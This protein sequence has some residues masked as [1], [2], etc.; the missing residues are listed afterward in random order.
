MEAMPPGLPTGLIHGD[1]FCDNVLFEGE[2]FKAIL[3][4]EDACH[5]YK[6]FDVGM[7]IVGV[8]RKAAS[9]DPGKADA[10][11]SG[12][13]EVRALE[14]AERANLQAFIECAAILTSVWRYWKYHIDAPDIEESTRY[15]EMVEIAKRVAAV[16]DAFLC[17]LSISPNGT[18]GLFKA[19]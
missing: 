14:E 13:Q 4:F 18:K 7:A 8:C 15:T 2:K 5:Y 16:P 1:L 11:V 19:D 3:D 9:I 6:A 10:F 12:Y 17:D